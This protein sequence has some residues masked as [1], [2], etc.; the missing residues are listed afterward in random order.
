MICFE[1]S[2]ILKAADVAIR[3]HFQS[4]NPAALKLTEHVY[5]KCILERIL[6]P[7]V[8]LKHNRV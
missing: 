5:R 1:A 7:T 6:K 4:S 3:A 8:L 2:P